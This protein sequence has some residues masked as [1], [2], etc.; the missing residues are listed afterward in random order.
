M[1]RNRLSS[2]QAGRQAD[3]HRPTSH[4][5]FALA[6]AGLAAFA[7]VACLPAPMPGMASRAAGLPTGDPPRAGHI[8]TTDDSPPLASDIDFDDWFYYPLDSAMP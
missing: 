8:E 4:H 5:S 6:V 7:A 2:N 1:D 3:G